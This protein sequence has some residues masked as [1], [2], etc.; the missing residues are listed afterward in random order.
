[1]GA[2]SDKWKDKYLRLLD[3]LEQQEQ[4]W[5]AMEAQLQR[6]IGR[7][8]VTGY[9][10]DRGLD[11]RLDRLRDAVRKGSSPDELERLSQDAGDWAAQL[12]E[13]DQDSRQAIFLSL[14]GLMQRMTVPSALQAD[15]SRLQKR[16]GKG[17]DPAGMAG[18]ADELQRLLAAWEIREQH[19]VVPAEGKKGLLTGW[20]VRK[21][22]PL[23]GNAPESW[24]HLTQQ[25]LERLPAGH[26]AAQALHTASGEPDLVDAL[27]RLL[28]QIPTCVPDPGNRPPEV[29]TLEPQHL[30]LKLVERT[31]FP[32]GIAKQAEQ[33][34]HQLHGNMLTDQE[35]FCSMEAYLQLVSNA[36]LQVIREKIELEKFLKG[37]TGRIQL[38][39][40]SLRLSSVVQSDAR[41]DGAAT[42]QAVRD[43][44]SNMRIQVS[45]AD[46]LGV[47]KQ[48]MEA[49]LDA[50]EA[51]VSGF[52]ARQERRHIAAEARIHELD[53][54]LQVLTFETGKLQQ[55]I[56][57]E[58]AQAVRDVLTGVYNRMAWEEH[59]RKEYQRWK[60]YPEPLSLV[61]VDV[62]HFKQV[63]DHFG[64]QAG[65][66]VLRTLAMCMREQLRE[67]DFLARYGGEE[68]IVMMP[69]TPLDHAVTAAEKL[70]VHIE[71]LSFVYQDQAVPVTVSCGVAEY[72]AGDSPAT[73]FE[74]AD[75][76]VYLAKHLGRN[77]VCSELEL[78]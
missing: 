36:K 68:F 6:S 27:S 40:N 43:E 31:D 63:N 25:L 24:N 61:I 9:G 11:L 5:Q 35:L 42:Q 7:L 12:R 69:F 73:A 34:A 67:T 47:L 22:G 26:P 70:R 53:E 77:R 44:V 74:R 28:V 51:H 64:H 46:D 54:Q 1:M 3:D 20:L 30:L 8:A 71:S 57:E 14:N 62:D 39:D 60:R 29:G 38:L 66:K 32:Q 72:H 33:L 52:V 17:V 76:A 56:R 45:D 16:L 59:V 78:I 58:R 2:E 13:E 55:R 10:L 4:R 41:Q 21:D 65:D 37:V 23:A 18:F 48:A 75:K 19:T 15:W 50:V 49:S